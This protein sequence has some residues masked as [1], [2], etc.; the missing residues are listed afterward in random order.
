MFFLNLRMF[1]LMGLLFAIIYAA[2][3]V[4]G[5]GLGITNFYFYLILSLGLM[6]FQYMIGPKMVEWMMR[7][8]YVKKEEYPSLYQMVE[9][10]A[11]KAKIPM[12]KVTN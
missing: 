1:L 8:K 10:L 6:F 12:P 2:M 4:I 5:A 9:D 3:V 7:V 11:N